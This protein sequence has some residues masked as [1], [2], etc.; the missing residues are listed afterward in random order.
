MSILDRKGND[1]IEQADIM[2]TLEDALRE[3][4]QLTL[5]ASGFSMGKTLVEADALIIQT[6]RNHPLPIGSIAVF[7]RNNQWWAHRVIWDYFKDNAVHYITKGDAIRAI[8]KPHVTCS[9]VV[10]YV[11]AYTKDSKRVE[12]SSLKQRLRGL[13]AAFV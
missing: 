8:D 3:Q 11:S 5:P 1:M 9:D 12:I 7:K 10:G 6:V 4:T 13:V 2:D